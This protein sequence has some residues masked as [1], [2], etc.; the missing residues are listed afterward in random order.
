ME[1]EGTGMVPRPDTPGLGLGMPLIATVSSRFDVRT[2][3]QGG[4]RLCIWFDTDPDATL[5]LTDSTRER[6]GGLTRSPDRGFT[7]FRDK[8]YRRR[9]GSRAGARRRRPRRHAG[10]GRDR[11]AERGAR[12]DADHAGT[13]A[14]RAGSAG[15]RRGGR[16]LRR[17]VRR[18]D[19]RRAAHRRPLHRGQERRHGVQADR[20]QRHRAGE[21][22]GPLLERAG[23]HRARAGE[24]R[25]RVRLR[26][27]ERPDAHARPARRRAAVGLPDAQRRRREPRRL[28]ERADHPRRQRREEQRRRALLLGPDLPARRA[29]PRRGRH[30]VL[31]RP[32]G[33]RQRVRHLRARGAAQRADLRPEDERVDADGLDGGRPLVPDADDAARRR[34]LRRERRAEAAQARLPEPPAGLG[35]ERPA[36]RDLRRGDRRSGRTTARARASRCRSSRGCTCCPTATS[37]S[38]RPGSRSTRSASPTT[39]RRG[40]SRRPTTRRRRRGTTSASPASRGRR[41]A[42]EARAARLPRVD[43]Q[44]DAAA[45]AAVHGRRRS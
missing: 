15:H 43:V 8:G 5:P 22:Q 45:E 33:R 2:T 36:D 9:G 38:T 34:R 17:A 24:H 41:A 11:W 20:R 25:R 14:S 31:P 7:A 35:D 42:T 10:A 1:D 39:R 29:R 18:A 12:A 44:R 40:T 4:T 21:R 13:G 23:G 19:D 37:S 28:P 3:L 26:R 16:P 6:G 30:G 27:A 32:R